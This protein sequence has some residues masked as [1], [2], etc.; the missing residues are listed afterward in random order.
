MK[1]KILNAVYNAIDEI[2]AGLPDE[3]SKSEDTVLF[4]TGGKLD[5]L[6]LVTFIVSVESNIEEA[7][8]RQITLAN[9]TALSS[10]KSPF[11]SVSALANYIEQ[12]L[13]EAPN[14]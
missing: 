10:E 5:S 4:G 3:L 14:E 8:D 12:L 7:F 9:E 2:N 1:E 13:N 6:A 11:A